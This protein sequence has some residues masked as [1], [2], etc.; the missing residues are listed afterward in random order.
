M[1]DTVNIL[2]PG[3]EVTA[4]K[5]SV[6]TPVSSLA[7][8]ILP[9]PKPKPFLPPIVSQPLGYQ[10]HNPA[11]P[12]GINWIEMASDISS[13]LSDLSNEIMAQTI[14]ITYHA[15]SL[16]LSD[17]KTADQIL[18]GSLKRSPSY[19][20]KYGGKTRSE[21]SELAKKGDQSASK[22]KKL[23]DQVDRLL[24]KNKRKK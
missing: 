9:L 14:L 1:G 24:Q 23:I 16:L 6:V 18:P 22:M 3:V 13:E 7:Q 2:L 11:G 15:F 20:P 19:N 12:L 17:E 8:I 21:L 5:R 10:Q 4:K